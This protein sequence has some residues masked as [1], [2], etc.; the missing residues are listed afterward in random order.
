MIWILAKTYPKSR[1]LILRN[2]YSTLQQTT[3]VTFQSLL[4]QGLQDDVIEW[5]QQTLTATLYNESQV[6]FMAESY[7]SDKELNRFRG[8]EI[9]GAGVDEANEIQEATF[10]KIIERAGSWQHSK[11]CPIKILLTCNPTHN[12]VKEKFY[13]KWVNKNLP[14]G[15]AYVPAKITDNPHIDPQYIESL[16]LLPIYEYQAFVEG[17]WEVVP[18]TGGEFYKLF[19]YDVNTE[20]NIAYSP[21][22]PLH[23]SFDFNVNPYISV[24]IWQITGKVAKQIDE[25]CMTSPRNR[26]ED[27]CKEFTRRYMSHAA[28][29]F[30]YG[31]PAGRHEDT[32]T[33]KGSNDFTLIL[34]H[35]AV[36]KPSLRIASAAPPVVMRGNFINTVFYSTFEGVQLI[37]SRKCANTI[38]DYLYLKEDSDGTKSK[39]KETNPDTKV[40]FE[41]YGHCFVGETMVTTIGGQK[42]I[43]GI[44]VGDLVLTRRGYRPV[45]KV[46]DNGV[47]E[48]ATYRIGDVK[49]TC[50]PEHLFFTESGFQPI[51]QLKKENIFCI[52][53]ETTGICKKTLYI[54]QESSLR[55]TPI[56]QEE[57]TGFTIRAEFCL[58]IKRKLKN[59]FT[60]LSICLKKGQFT[61]ATTS[62]MLM[63]TPLITTP[64]TLHVF[65]GVNIYRTTTTLFLRTIKTIKNKYL[66]LLLKKLQKSGTSQLKAGSGT[67]GNQKKILVFKNGYAQSVEENSKKYQPLSLCTVPGDVEKELPQEF[68]GQRQRVYDLQV[69]DCHEY[70]ANG[71]LVHNC[72]DANDYLICMAFAGEFARYQ[73]GGVGGK[74]TTGRNVSKSSY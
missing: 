15:W 28:G 8:L 29:L 49:T 72:S 32:R 57:V 73:K 45:K 52:F 74:T 64:P 36:F 39:K 61:T 3:L 53:N 59:G 50:T 10:N 11:G 48:V 17:D 62:T 22:L 34:K 19:D 42:R 60:G 51:F 26:T 27:A 47:K 67:D 20:V 16:K 31:D 14:P 55:D 40:S 6:F 56:H 13:D 68:S 18:R 30:V 25:I 23:I 46:Y 1:W 54:T 2:S 66:S 65:Q 43:D 58:M 71:I 37:I 38:N 21:Q 44:Q 33:E 4:Q 63:T 5:K 35:L 24:T 69:E 9:N 70:F 12:W 7:D 41:K